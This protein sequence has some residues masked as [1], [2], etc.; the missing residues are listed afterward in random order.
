MG[1]FRFRRS[2]KIAPGIRWNI[3]KKSTSFSIGPRGLKL[4]AGT[5]GLRTTVGIPGTG[6]SYTSQLRHH[7]A[8]PAAQPV[9]AATPP[10]PQDRR[11]GALS[12]TV[13][14]GVIAVWTVALGAKAL[15]AVVALLALLAFR[16][17][18]RRT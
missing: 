12:L 4:T 17:R 8:P 5:R 13:M 18:R 11:L 16:A 2:I 10:A 9:D 7:H 1:F 15:G 14:I 6:I 3:G